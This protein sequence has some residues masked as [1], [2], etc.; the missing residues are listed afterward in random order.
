M[1]LVISVDTAVA[2]LAGALARPLWLLLAE[3]PDFRWLEAREDT[4]WYPTARLHRRTAEGWPPLIAR[5]ARHL[6]AA[7]A[8]H[9]GNTL[10]TAHHRDEAI[11]AYAAAIA[12]DPSHADAHT[13]L[14]NALLAQDR[15]QDAIAAYRAG[16]ATNPGRAPLHYNLAN[17]LMADDQIEA[18]EPEF[19]AALALAPSHA[20][21]HN[22][23]GN[24]LRAQS[25][26]DEALASYQAALALRPDY[27]GTLNNIG[28]T[29]IALHRPDEAD[30]LL[31]RALALQPAYAEAANNLGGALLALDR[32]R[33]AL[34]AFEAAVTA[35]PA[36]APA[37]FGAALA[38][39]AEGDFRQGWRDYESRWDDPRF[40]ADTPP[41]TTP[42]WSGGDI[43][44][45]Q[46]ML[47]HAEQGLGDT[48]QFA[49]YAPLLRQRG[50]HVTLWVQAPL[51]T[52]L[53][54]L[55]DEIIA[56]GETPET[57]PIP[58]HDLRSP[59]LSLP[60]ALGTRLATIPATIPYLHP[61][62][63]RIA[64]WR[65]RLGPAAALR[66]GIAFSG[67]AD[68]PEDALRS[69]PAATLI[70]AL[71]GAEL[72]VVQKDIRPPDAATL[73]THPAI[74]RHDPTDFAD[75]AGLLA[76]LDLIVT[77]DTSIA[78]LAGAIGRP[79]W[80]LLQ[81]AADFRWLR[82]RTDSPWYP[83]AR[84]FRQTT[85]GD[86][87]APLTALTAALASLP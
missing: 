49:R 16:I 53:A 64:T 87:T 50:A 57:D 10:W 39:L 20:G 13:H 72:H 22:N 48:I 58:P 23:L 32:P 59:L 21:A 66:I 8:F 79:V 6:A 47:L 36:M 19:R 3:Q 42:I 81:Y 7:A 73:A 18:A 17:A 38:H 28:A 37:R 14:G 35:E 61:D 54:P 86:W 68:H 12:A 84:L 52:L 31:R 46:R 75:T 26:L 33:E 63:A 41:F 71:P 45:G 60:H 2:H 11:A 24:A 4:P 27:A 5:L 67:S 76:C 74:A 80:V 29:L 15:T 9:R 62:T 70:A 1:D 34:A 78:H 40:T 44:A 55:A 77:V 82:A 69:L 85:R 30:P 65:H 83:T 51:A 43:L 25:R 56:Q